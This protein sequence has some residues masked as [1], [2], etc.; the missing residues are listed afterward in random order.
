[1]KE[2]QGYCPDAYGFD[3][4]DLALPPQFV[5]LLGY[6]PPIIREKSRRRF[7]AFYWS[8]GEFF[9]EDGIWST[10]GFRQP[11]H[12]WHCH[13]SVQSVSDQYRFGSREEDSRHWLLV[14]RERCDLFV[15]FGDEVRAFLLDEPALRAER[16]AAALRSEEQRQAAEK[17][18]RK[19]K[20]IAVQQLDAWFE[21]NRSPERRQ[22]V[23]M[24]LQT[25]VVARQRLLDEMVWWLDQQQALRVCAGGCREEPPSRCHP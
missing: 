13:R 2:D 22:A 15:G 6:G 24:R 3:K 16:E 7:V 21:R 10:T 11:W 20:T 9:F 18:A 8:A 17:Y 4:L 1:M 19:K 12:I 14:D 5:L 25:V 23:R